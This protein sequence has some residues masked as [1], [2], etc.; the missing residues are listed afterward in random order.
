MVASSDWSGTRVLVVVNPA[1]RKRAD[2]VVDVVQHHAPPGAVL[3]VRYTIRDQPVAELIESGVHQAAIIIAV[4]GDGTVADVVTALGDMDIPVGII[5]AGSTNIVARENRIPLR[6]D[7]AAALIFGEHRLAR[8][9]VGVSGERRFLHM[10]GAGLDSRLFAATNPALKRRMGWPAYVPAALRNL[11]APP[12]RFR[13]TVDGSSF[14]CRS[15]LVLVA[16]G[17]AIIRPSLPVYPD[18]RRNDGLLDVI[19]FTSAGPLQV[20]ST[21]LRFAARRLDRSPYVVRLR[22]RNVSLVADPPIPFQLDGD[23]AGMTPA[24]FYMLPGAIRLIV[25]PQ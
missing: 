24:D 15:P 17:A 7:A 2:R 25:P 12:V 13:I 21:L 19:A 16:N 14:Q 6:P 8:L 9:D 20:G 18:L 1:T 3:D 4:G 22:G 10:A 5:P 11:L 23:V